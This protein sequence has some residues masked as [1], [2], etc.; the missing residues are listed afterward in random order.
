M[1]HAS[2]FKRQQTFTQRDEARV[3]MG[4]VRIVGHFAGNVVTPSMNMEVALPIEHEVPFAVVKPVLVSFRD[5]AEAAGKPE[6]TALWQ[7]LIGYF[8]EEACNLPAASGGSA[9]NRQNEA[10]AEAIDASP[11]S[12]CP[13]QIPKQA[14]L[15]K[16]LE[17]AS[18][19]KLE[20]LLDA[21][22]LTMLLRER[23]VELLDVRSKYTQQQSEIL[24]LKL[25]NAMLA[26]HLASVEASAQKLRNSFKA[27]NQQCGPISGSPQRQLL[28]ADLTCKLGGADYAVSDNFSLQPVKMPPWPGDRFLATA[29][30]Q[31]S[32]EPEPAELLTPNPQELGVRASRP[33]PPT[34]TKVS[35]RRMNDD[36][37][38]KAP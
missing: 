35:L 34:P 8:P 13:G 30:N 4:K 17:S 36:A 7:N 16:L 24:Q 12:P 28:E 32:L 15:R 22:Q 14:I 25:N 31:C 37:W 9:S 23:S 11:C 20:A 29:E 27:L 1:R 5:T 19:S 26:G 2:H 21:E 18:K 3:E 38:I 10:I 33:G 6:I